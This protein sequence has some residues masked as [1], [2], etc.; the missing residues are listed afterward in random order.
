MDDDLPDRTNYRKRI[1]AMRPADKRAEFGSLLLLTGENIWRMGVI[2]RSM[3]EAGEDYSDLKMPV[4]TYLLKVGYG[5]VLP[6]VV[7]AFLGMPRLL[8]AVA[9]L[10]LSDQ[11]RLAAGESI[12]VM[13]GDADAHR[14]LRVAD[15]SD[16]ERQQVFGA[17]YI[18][19]E[20]EQLAWLRHHPVADPTP[21]PADPFAPI[22][23]D[24]V[25]NGLRIGHTFLPASQ[26]A[27]ALNELG[28]WKVTPRKP[29]GKAGN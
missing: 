27:A 20:A 24:R 22:V 7:L 13:T 26:W 1:D 8:R 19:D 2:L 6:D 11:K 4:M 29:R 3:D 17:D 15:M 23:I 18:R 21:G 9:A 16:S 28:G 10:P 5:Q 25:R 12:K 14:L